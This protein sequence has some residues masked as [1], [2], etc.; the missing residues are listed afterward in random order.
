MGLR[1]WLGLG[2]VTPPESPANAVDALCVR[3][4]ATYERSIAPSGQVQMRLIRPDATLSATGATT[5]DAILAL[6]AKA[7][8]WESL[9]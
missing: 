3:F 8:A 5:R 4:G 2:V 7:A 9:L 1:Q 6:E